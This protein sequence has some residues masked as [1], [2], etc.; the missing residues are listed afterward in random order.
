MGKLLEIIQEGLKLDNQNNT[1]LGDRS[2]YVGASDVGSCLRNAYLSKLNTVDYSAE[3]LLVLFRGQIAE[4]IVR[5]GLVAKGIPYT[6]QAE[7]KGQGD[8]DFVR[9]HPDFLFCSASECVVVECKTVRDLIP[10]APYE[11]WIYQVQLQLHLT[12]QTYGKKTR[13]YVLAI[14]LGSGKMQDYEVSYNPTLVQIAL[15]RA[16]MLW[17]AMKDKTEPQA[18]E[19]MYCSQ[20]HFKGSCPKMAGGLEQAPDDIAM[21]ARRLKELSSYEKEIKALKENLKAFMEASGAKKLACG[22]ITLQYVTR[23]GSAT[24]DVARLKQEMPE[25]FETFAKQGESYSYVQVK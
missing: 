17:Q 11:S 21:M 19:Q 15:D 9:V 7:L 16:T 14:E 2:K 25:I 13:G 5:R 18:E 8:Y 24:I 12:M 10:E 4:E 23:K 6:Y 22:D 1:S 3:Q 20:C